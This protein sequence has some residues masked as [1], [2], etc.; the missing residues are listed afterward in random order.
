MKSFQASRP[1]LRSTL[2]KQAMTRNFSGSS[3]RCDK[4]PI[5]VTGRGKGV[6]QQIHVVDSPHT[7]SVDTYKS[8]GGAE[9]APSPLAYNLSSL[10]SCTQVTGSLVAK[11]VGITL[12]EWNVSVDGQLDPAVLVGGAEGN[13]NWDSVK[14]TVVLRTDAEQSTFDR[15]ASETERRCPLTQLFKRSG[16][17]WESSWKRENL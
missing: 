9:S 8:F 5:S 3:L 11:D 10:A 2:G 14:L 17:K 6:A 15:F 4:V 13:S 7:I 1:L 16:V 12:G